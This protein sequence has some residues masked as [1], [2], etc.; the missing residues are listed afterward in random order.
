MGNNKCEQ[1]LVQNLL[2]TGKIETD[3]RIPLFIVVM[4]YIYVSVELNRQRSHCPTFTL[5]T[6]EYGAKVE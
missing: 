6:S 1:V 2:N 5:Y 3:G 4:G